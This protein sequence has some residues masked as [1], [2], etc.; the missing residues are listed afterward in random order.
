VVLN[1]TDKSEEKVKNTFT[2]LIEKIFV[3]TNPLYTGIFLFRLLPMHTHLLV[4]SHKHAPLK[5]F[6]HD[7]GLD[8]YK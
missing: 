5:F 4:F 1:Y 3:T 8:A 7:L 6:T 2:L